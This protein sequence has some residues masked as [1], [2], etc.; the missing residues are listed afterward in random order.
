MH[1]FHLFVVSSYCYLILNSNP[2]QNCNLEL[3]CVLTLCTGINR[4]NRGPS[5]EQYRRCNLISAGTLLCGLLQRGYPR[6]IFAAA[7]QSSNVEIYMWITEDESN[8]DDHKCQLTY[9]DLDFVFRFII[10]FCAC[11]LHSKCLQLQNIN[12]KHININTK[13]CLWATKCNS[14]IISA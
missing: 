5:G 8:V 1:S 7:L 11:F 13:K 4:R 10:L 2:A 3:S 9:K 14:P 12:T 6:S